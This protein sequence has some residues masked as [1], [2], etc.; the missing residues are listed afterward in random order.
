MNAKQCFHSDRRARW[1][2]SIVHCKTAEC[3]ETSSY[4]WPS[5]EQD[6]SP[7]LFSAVMLIQTL[8]IFFILEYL[9]LCWCLSRA[10]FF[11]SSA[12]ARGLHVSM[13]VFEVTKVIIFSPFQS[14]FS[15]FQVQS[16][17]LFDTGQKPPF[18]SSRWTDNIFFISRGLGQ[19]TANLWRSR[20]T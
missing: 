5:G 19:S 4:C 18:M 6:R 9:Y 12:C 13:I 1:V 16:S 2:R 10:R 7:V 17:Q 8:L 15:P 20:D 3:L 14:S 11:S